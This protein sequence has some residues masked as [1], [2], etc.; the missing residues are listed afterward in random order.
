[1]HYVARWRMHVATQTLRNTNASLAQVAA[2]VGY[3]SEAAFSRAF[4]KPSVRRRPRGALD[5]V[6]QAEAVDMR[7]CCAAQK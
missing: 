2:S 6:A 5:P 1:M 4:K 7:A 3:D